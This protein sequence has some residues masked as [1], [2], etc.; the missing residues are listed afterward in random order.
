MRNLH[1]SQTLFPEYHNRFRYTVHVSL[2]WVFIKQEVLFLLSIRTKNNYQSFFKKMHVHYTCDI[3]WVVA[4][5]L[6]CILRDVSFV[7]V[8]S[9]CRV[10]LRQPM[11]L[12]TCVSEEG[13]DGDTI[14]DGMFIINRDMYQVC[15]ALPAPSRRKEKKKRK[16]RA[17]QFSYTISAHDSKPRNCFLTPR[18]FS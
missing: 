16:V 8:G 3:P 14:R 9:V 13:G 2:R 6:S 7:E 10:A 1:V 11:H 12:C 17:F 18:Y 5:L 15:T 4:L